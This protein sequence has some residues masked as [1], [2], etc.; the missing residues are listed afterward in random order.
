MSSACTVIFKDHYCAMAEGVE[1]LILEHLRAIL[2][3]NDRTHQML[4]DLTQRVASLEQKAAFAAVDL[5]ARM[6]GIAHPLDRIE[7]RLGLVEA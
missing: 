5:S 3:G 6:V 2:A 7:K 1:N 4:F